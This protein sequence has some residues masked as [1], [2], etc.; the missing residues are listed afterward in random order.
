MKLYDCAI[1]PN[2]R[3]ARIFI[4]EKG[5]SLPKVEVDLLGGENREPAYLAINPRGL[6][7][8]LQLE[9]GVVI[10]EVVAICRYLEELHPTPPL[11][12]TTPVERA[13]VES[14][15]RQMEFE[16]M[17]AC[18]EVFRNSD[19]RF[20]LRSL[21]GNADAIP[22]IPGLVARGTQTLGRFFN[23]L[24]RYLGQSEFVAGERFTLA[25]ITALCAVDFAGWVNLSIPAT[26]GRVRHWY[27][28][29][30]SRP[31]AKA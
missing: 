14:R 9:E 11:L 25:D 21:P 26:H 27:D 23:T 2:P 31:S 3:R 19:P 12:G 13:V 24:E 18:S 7:P 17:I 15:Q 28:A 4:A 30:S 8:A 16:G 6:V 22:A 10:D 29:V 1:A 20:A 5:L